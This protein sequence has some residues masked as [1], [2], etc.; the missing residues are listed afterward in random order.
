MIILQQQKQPGNRHKRGAKMNNVEY[1][2]KELAVLGITPE[3]E[4]GMYDHIIGMVEKFNKENHSG[5][6]GNYALN[7][8]NKVLRYE[9]VTPLTGAEEEWKETFAGSGIFQNM[10]CFHVFRE[11]GKA[12]DT[13]GRVFVKPNGLAYGSS[14]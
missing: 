4:N 3:T 6:S 13:A 14:E 11:N 5:F 7:V 12:Y 2:K 9:P 1:T 10:R 8:L